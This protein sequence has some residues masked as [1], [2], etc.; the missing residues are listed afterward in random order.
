MN[1]Y[2]VR[3]RRG[4]TL[5]QRADPGWFR[6]INADLLDQ[7]TQTWCVLG[8]WAGTYDEGCKRLGVSGPQRYVSL[9]LQERDETEAAVHGFNLPNGEGTA[10]EWFRLNRAW[11]RR[12]RHLQ[13]SGD[14]GEPLRRITI[15]PLPETEPAQ[16]PAAPTPERE[17]E[18]A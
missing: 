7:R 18:P 4:E 16:E 1:K 10:W 8:Q 2:T 17:R 13:R 12:I 3:Q 15:E 6:T 11:K 14:V 9:F 5:L